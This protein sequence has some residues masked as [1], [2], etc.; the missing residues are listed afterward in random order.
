MYGRILPLTASLLLLVCGAKGEGAVDR[1]C[2]R[3]RC[4]GEDDC[5]DWCASQT[6]CLIRNGTQLVEDVACRVAVDTKKDF[7]TVESRAD[8][9]QQNFKSGRGFEELPF[10]LS[11]YSYSGGLGQPA[12]TGLDLRVQYSAFHKLRFR[13]KNLNPNVCPDHGHL[14][15]DSNCNPR[16]VSVERAADGWSQQ[17]SQV[18]LS[19]LQFSYDCEVGFYISKD[20][21]L[22][23]ESTRDSYV[24]SVC[25]DSADTDLGTRCGEYL[26]MMPGP[27]ES[28][29]EEFMMVLVDRLEFDTRNNIVLYALPPSNTT[30]LLITL[31]LLGED[32]SNTPV[33]N[34]TEI[35]KPAGG[36]N[37]PTRVFLNFA[38]S[39]GRYQL[40]VTALGG[41]EMDQQLQLRGL[42]YSAPLVLPHSSLHLLIITLAAG[43]LLLGL[44]LALYR[45]WQ[46]VAEEGA[47]E[48]QLLIDAGRIQ[49]KPVLVITS[50]HNTKHSQIVK[51]L[52]EYLRKWCGVGAT[53]FPLD[54]E[55]GIHCGQRDPWKWCQESFERVKEE[56][57]SLVFLAGPSPAL[58]SSS[59]APSL[60]PGLQDNQAFLATKDLRLLAQQGRVLVCRLPY[61]SLKSLPAEVPGHLTSRTLLLPRDMNSFLS[62]LL[63]VKR[64]TLCSWAPFSL[65]QPEIL[66]GDLS[67]PGGP[68]L[69]QSIKELTAQDHQL[70]MEQAALTQ[71][72]LIHR[73]LLHKHQEARPPAA[74]RTA[75]L[76]PPIL[77]RRPDEREEDREA[78]EPLVPPPAPD[79][80]L[81]SSSNG[82]V[83]RIELEQEMPTLQEL[84]HRDR[85]VDPSA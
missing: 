24:L 66:P 62:R 81:S 6:S 28:S 49:P 84:A 68:Q 47:V 63:Q 46:Q 69:L 76:P 39:S 57:G 11:A 10:Y 70:R 50:L 19:G 48:P 16:C 15:M 13:F 35:L 5:P 40:V 43:V 1:L 14:T 23:I 37:V 7:S 38:P 82:G 64:K 65:V 56:G 78:A 44:L 75:S 58:S 77:R 2:C 25:A 60:Y 72:K 30:Q 18:L 85:T 27:V 54:D 3:Y 20:S 71:T 31:L 9:L 33:Y 83:L 67:R 21:N 41:E 55:V 34:Q 80:G 26:F 32:E 29:S 51:D 73:F 61:S 74:G 8:C 59:P 36:F 45:R 52:C 79:K 4:Q 12:F 17:E 22:W 53:Y 42:S